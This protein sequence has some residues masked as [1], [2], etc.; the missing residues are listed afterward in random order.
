MDAEKADENT[1]IDSIKSNIEFKGTNLWTLIFAILIAS[2]GLNVNS[3]AV[4]IGA[5]LIS[6]LM[7]PIMGIGLGAGIFDFQLIKDALKNLFVAAAISLIASTVYFF[8]SPLHEAR[9]ELLARTTPT[10]WDV[11]IALFGGLAGIIASSR[12]SITNAI[13]GVAIATALM[14]PLCTA[15][16]GLGTGNIYYFLG[17]FYLFLINCVFISV[18]TFL[19]VRYLKFKPVH[20]VNEEMEKKVRKYIWWIAILTIIPSIF[21]AYRFVEQEIFKQNAESFIN[22]EVRSNGIFVIDKTIDVRDRRIELFVYGEKLTDSLSRT[23]VKKKKLYG[24]EKAEVIIE[25]TLNTNQRTKELIAEKPDISLELKTQLIE[26]DKLINKLNMR[27]NSQFQAADSSIYREFSA[28]YGKPKE[29]IIS[30]TLDFTEKG[31]DTI[32]LVYYLLHKKPK[33][34]DKSQLENWLKERTKSKRLKVV[35]N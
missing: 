6:P 9:S 16:Y 15:G 25:Q 10:I 20:L 32:T 17:A 22:R 21:L 2:I 8:I 11:L 3:T 13:P 18:S 29:L 5:M 4:I 30:R 26:K 1:I 27:I 19:I 31:L 14:P 28:L 12:K 35:S 34:I 23:I 24:L 7:G 33:H